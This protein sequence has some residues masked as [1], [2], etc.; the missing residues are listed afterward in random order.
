MGKAQTSIYASFLKL[1]FKSLRPTSITDLCAK[2]FLAGAQ[3]RG[4][5]C[6]VEL[7]FIMLSLFC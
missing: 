6:L 1:I 7:R 2:N 5:P 3:M 4:Y